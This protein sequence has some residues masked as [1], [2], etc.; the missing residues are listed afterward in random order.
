MAISE[1]GNLFGWG[2]NNQLQLSHGDEYSQDE[3]PW[4]AI[5]YPV[6]VKKGFEGKFV[7]DAAGGE[8]FSIIHTRDPNNGNVEEIY[9]CGNNLRG[10]LGINRVSHLQDVM[11][12]EDVSGFVDQSTGKPLHITN[13]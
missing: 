10:Q 8:E 1:E 6:Q 13:I 11:L 2:Y 5:F 4:H 7:L 9:S 12:V 3:N